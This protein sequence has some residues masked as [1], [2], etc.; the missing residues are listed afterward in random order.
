MLERRHSCDQRSAKA[1]ASEC[2]AKVAL[3]V[4]GNTGNR[5]DICHP[6]REQIGDNQ[7][8]M[9]HQVLEASF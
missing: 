3:G 1:Q 5:P 8:L 2:C 7:N 4:W 6:N 9:S